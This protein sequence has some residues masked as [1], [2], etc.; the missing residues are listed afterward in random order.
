M[1]RI[2]TEESLKIGGVISDMFDL[3]LKMQGR[4]LSWCQL[5]WLFLGRWYYLRT[6]SLE[7][8]E[9]QPLL[10]VM[11]CTFFLPNI[12]GF[13]P[14]LWHLWIVHP[15]WWSINETSRWYSV[16]SGGDTNAN[17]SRE[18]G[19]GGLWLQLPPSGR[20]M[21]FSGRC[22]ELRYHPIK[23]NIYSDRYWRVF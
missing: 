16:S 7:L 21:K 6:Q 9:N 3:L 10:K 2:M 18:R 11:G 22:Q 5:T 14:H 20:D 1:W 13:F 23:M 8:Q 4:F 15:G 19:K 17:G 12:Q